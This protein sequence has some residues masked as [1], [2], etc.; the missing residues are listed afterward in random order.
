VQLGVDPYGGAAAESV[1][2]LRTR[3]A[4]VDE[5]ILVGGSPAVQ[6]DYQAAAVRDTW[7]VVP[8]VL[9]AVALIL[10]LLLRS[11]IA[12]ILLIGTVVLSFAAALGLSSLVFTHLLGYGG[13]A[14]DLVIYVF[15]FLVALGVDYHIFLMDRVREQRRRVGTAVAVRQGLTATG[16]VITAAGLVLAGTFSALAQ[17]PDV[18][19]AQV[20]IAVAIGVLIDTMVVR[21]VQVPALVT[22]LGDRT[23]WPSRRR[24]HSGNARTS[25]RRISHDASSSGLPT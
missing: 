22:I 15:V 6:A 7:T 1:R 10:G 11:L 24:D 23:W 5:A 25:E 12:P 18:T 19:V 20:G 2:S 8:L 9:L 13:V 14:A 3:L 21:T 17:L 16:G 4:A